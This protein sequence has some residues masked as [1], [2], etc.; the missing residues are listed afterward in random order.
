MLVL[1]QTID[2]Q[3]FLS[4]FLFF[5]LSGDENWGGQCS[6]GRRQSPIDLA[7]EASVIGRYPALQLTNY[8]QILK[9]AKV[10]NTGHSRESFRIAYVD[11]ALDLLCIILCALWNRKQSNDSTLTTVYS[12]RSAIVPSYECVVNVNATRA[13]IELVSLMQCNAMQR[14]ATHK[15]M[16]LVAMGWL[17]WVRI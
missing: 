5:L 15:R 10:R 12:Y 7:E 4:D 2:Q 1:L 14:D 11:P 17:V 8:D 16:C 9:N 6:Q 3:I 13:L